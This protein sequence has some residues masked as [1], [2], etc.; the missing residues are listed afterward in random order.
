MVFGNLFCIFSVDNSF[1]SI[2]YI[3]STGVIAHTLPTKAQ[4]KYHTVGSLNCE[5]VRIS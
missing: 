3:L 5:V 2:S 1:F 4:Y